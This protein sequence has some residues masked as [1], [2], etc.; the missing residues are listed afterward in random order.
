MTGMSRRKN[1]W[2]VL[3]L[4]TVGLLFA[5]AQT[6][7]WAADPTPGSA[8]AARLVSVLFSWT[9]LIAMTAVY[10]LCLWSEPA[11]ELARVA[12]EIHKGKLPLDELTNIGGIN[13]GMLPLLKVLREIL[14]DLKQQKGAIA[15]VRQ[16]MT[17]R[18]AVK[19]ESLERKIGSLKAQA[20]HDPLT[21]LVNRRGLDVELTRAVGK[22]ESVGSDACVLMIDVDHF[23]GLNDTLGHAAGDELLKSIAQILRSSIRDGDQ[24]CRCGGDEFVVL[25]NGCGIKG[26]IDLAE[27]LASLVSALTKPLRVRNPPSLSIGAC[28]LKELET[29]TAEMMLKTADERL[30]AVKSTRPR[31]R[32][33]G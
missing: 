8:S 18:V 31:T 21:G 27:R 17:L 23:K 14:I 16:E 26:G 20:A 5:V 33:A 29:P 25:L 30:Y 24:A 13:S 12:S 10:H 28:A 6:L 2:I 4:F 7:Q 15:E 19:T 32:Q 11:R 3:S 1:F 9:P 22:F